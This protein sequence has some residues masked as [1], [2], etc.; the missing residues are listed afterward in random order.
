MLTRLY[1]VFVVLLALPV[2]VAAQL[3][4]IHLADGDELRA[5][6]ERQS[7]SVIELA[8][9][10]GAILD[11]RGRALVVNTARFEVAA[12]PTVAG[13]EERADELYALLGELTGRGTSHFRQRVANRSSRQYVVLVRDLDEAS[14]EA[15]DAGGFRGLIV[16]GSYQRRYNY[17]ARAAHVLGHVTRDLRGVAGLEMTLD[18]A[19]QGAPGRQA[20]QRDRRGHVRAV[21]GGTR[22][23]PRQGDNVVLTIDLVRQAILEEEL[24]RGVEAAGAAWGTAVAL[25]PKTGA[26]LAMA[27]VPTYDP[28]RAGAYSDAAR[29]NHAVVDRIEPGSTFKLVTAIAAV[30]SGAVAPEDV[31]DTGAGWHVFHG[32]TVQDAHAYG[33]IT[34]AQAIAKSS[35]IAMA[36]AAQRI[37]PGPL[38]EA[39]RD[40]GFGQPTFVD[41]PG[42][43]AGSLRKPEDWSGATLTSM[44]RGYGVEVT[45]LQLAVAY[46]AFANG[47]LLVR[48]FIVAER[49][50][51]ATGRVVWQAPQDSVRRAFRAETAERLMPHFEAVVS[52]DGTAERAAVEGLRIAGKTGTAQ[53]AV[54]GGYSRTYRA[55]F[56]G[57]FPVEDPEVVLAIVLDRPT[58]GYGGGTVAAPIFGATARR[59]IGTFPTIAERVAPSGMIAARTGALVPDI[60]G[61]PATLAAQRAR[62]EGLRVRY[63]EDLPWRTVSA[64]VET[65]SL[66]L[67]DPLRL[68]ASDEVAEGRMPDLRGRSVREAVAWL[69]SLGVDARVRGH[70]VVRRQSVAPARPLPATVALTA[71]RR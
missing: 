53:R 27:N 7:E 59:W 49:R 65:D 57:M 37:G 12:D 24:A 21:V 31:F 64:R 45:P 9:Q 48:P 13:F 8:A 35:N 5:Q 26:I 60:D 3:V 68:D 23:E 36:L 34:F 17:G 50:D 25:D 51:P 11:R 61:L 18:E 47:G 2:L 19:L 44:S 1:G 55:S 43:V 52:E 67:R 46:S 22:V 33:R 42:E 6:G 15:L 56:V 63:D 39:A 14:K 30:E 69:R 28:N 41:L 32:R 4:R 66:D 70:G 54:G 16:Q 62:A 38:Y 40:L 71:S 29:R 58:N 10:R 20:V